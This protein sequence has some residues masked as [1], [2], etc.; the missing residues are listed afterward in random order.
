MKLLIDMNLSPTWCEYLAQ[1]GIE[2]VHW[3][4][5]GSASAADVEIMQHAKEHSL[6]VM[7]HDLD[8]GAVLAATK[9]EG[10]SVIQVR[11]VDPTPDAL[12]SIVVES[13]TQFGEVLRAGA[14]V[15]VE[16]GHARARVLPIR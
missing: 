2:S 1:R 5:I 15:V 14:I 10:P 16:P 7:S 11:C 13:L 3:S 12:G 6:V 4:T 8:F 9:A